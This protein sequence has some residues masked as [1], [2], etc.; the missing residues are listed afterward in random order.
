MDSPLRCACPSCESCR[1]DVCEKLY[2][3]RNAHG[4]IV[5]LVCAECY[6]TAIS[7]VASVNRR[8]GACYNDGVCIAAP[9]GSPTYRSLDEAKAIL[10]RLDGSENA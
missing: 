1:R 5:A 4:Q 9:I 8:F 6:E 10:A 3:V 7:V 2:E